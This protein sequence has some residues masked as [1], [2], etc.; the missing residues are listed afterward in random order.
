[1]LERHGTVEVPEEEDVPEDANEDCKTELPV[2]VSLT[3][4]KLTQMSPREEDEEKEDMDGSVQIS[5]S[6]G[7]LVEGQ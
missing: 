3:H 5:L 7:P 1:M 2:Q 6:L 4:G